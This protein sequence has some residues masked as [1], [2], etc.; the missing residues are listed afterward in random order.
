MSIEQGEALVSKANFL[1]TKSVNQLIGQKFWIPDY[2][3]GYRWR[4]QEVRDLLNDM[5]NYLDQGNSGK[6]YSLQPVVVA[7]APNEGWWEVIDGQQ[8]LTTIKIIYQCLG[9]KNFEIDYQSREGSREFLNSLPTPNRDDG[10]NIDFFHMR[11]AT[12]VVQEWIKEVQQKQERDSVDVELLSFMGPRL[13]VIWYEVHETTPHEKIFTRLNIGKIPLTNAE[14]IKAVVLNPDVLAEPNV[15]QTQVFEQLILERQFA[16]ASE[17]D[18]IEKEL[19]NDD[20][21]FF[22]ANESDKFETRIDFVFRFLYELKENA[23]PS[24][25]DVFRFFEQWVANA[26]DSRDVWN[27]VKALYYKMK[28]WYD[29]KTVYHLSGFLNVVGYR[30]VEQ[31]QETEGMGKRALTDYLKS[32]VAKTVREIDI[33]DLNYVDESGKLEHVLLLFNILAFLRNPSTFERFSFSRYKQETWSLE[34]IHARNSEG[35]RST[36]DRLR[37]LRDHATLLS[38][39]GHQQGDQDA[40]DIVQQI[41]NLDEK[42]LD[43]KT[44]SILFQRIVA[45]FQEENI[46]HESEINDL[47]NLTLLPKNTNSAFG[48]AVFALKRARLIERERE[49]EHFLP[50]TR[51]V[52]MKYY[53]QDPKYMYFWTARDREDYIEAITDSFRAYFGEQLLEA[54]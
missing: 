29:N 41:R 1:G 23:K 46:E 38:R 39:N 44:F 20:F 47:G 2:Q 54:D 11:Q 5:L 14:L 22:I 16:I 9:R 45:K 17:W 7:Q 33:A 4:P 8:R 48:N 19:H 13:E 12:E 15:S 10:H 34:H 52:F 3:R 26:K 43:Q 28:D 30:L 53:S 31:F 18:A 50:A 36:A 6:S 24:E 40:M 21:W 27:E 35:I 51:N 32:K 25:Y 49:G 37:W 42:T